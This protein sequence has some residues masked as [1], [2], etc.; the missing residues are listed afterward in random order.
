L[1]CEVYKGSR[2]EG[3]YL[4]VADSSSLEN[5]PAALTEQLGDLEFVISFDLATR[6]SLAAAD[7]AEVMAS[8][9]TSGFYLQMPPGTDLETC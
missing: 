6:T 4:F 7:P 9:K 5:L 8:I 2:K 1:N 3:A